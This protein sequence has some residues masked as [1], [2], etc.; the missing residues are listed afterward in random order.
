M[1]TDVAAAP[2][3]IVERRYAV[4]FALVTTLFFSWALA[5]ALNDVLIRQFQK[6][7][8]TAITH[9]Q[10]YARVVKRDYV[11]KFQTMGKTARASH[12]IV[13]ESPTVDRARLKKAARALGDRA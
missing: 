10:R 2:P 9:L 7:L 12:G 11:Q 6:A 13:L 8:D 4:A 5:A 1:P 3:P